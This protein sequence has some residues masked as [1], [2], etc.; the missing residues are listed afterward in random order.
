[1]ILI[2]F[3]PNKPYQI[4]QAIKIKPLGLKC[5][6]IKLNNKKLNVFKNAFHAHIAEVSKGCKWIT[7]QARRQQKANMRFFSKK[8]SIERNFWVDRA[9]CAA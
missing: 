6:I 2:Q 8:T 4:K 5:L 3:H 1:M 9:N 7:N